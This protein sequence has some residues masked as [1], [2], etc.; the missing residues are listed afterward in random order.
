MW[1]VRTAG[2]ALTLAL[3]ASMSSVGAYAQTVYI[4]TNR[5][6]YDEGER[7][8]VAGKVSDASDRRPVLVRIS[9][10][11]DDCARQNVRPLRDGSF[12]SRPMVISGC[13]LG[14][15][16]VTATHAGITASTS[17][18]VEGKKEVSDSLELRAIRTTVSEAQ[19]AVNTRMREVL[20]ANLAIPERAAD[21]Y[22]RG[23]A[24]ASLTLQAI[25]RGNA[26]A[27]AEHMEVTLAYFEEALDL[28]SPE[29]L[30]T[31]AEDIREEQTRVSTVS[32][33]SGR[34]QDMFRRLVDLADKNG[35]A[36]EKEFGK[37]DKI[38]GDAQQFLNERKT[39]SAAESL[40]A[41]DGLIEEARQK[42]IRQAEG[43]DLQALSSATGRLEN[44]ANELRQDAAGVP[45]VL[46]Q[47]NASFVHINSAK[48]SIADGD[49]DS[50]K[51]SLDLA[52]KKL[53]EAKK[54]LSRR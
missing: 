50:A 2:I 52:L 54:I 16:S 1:W 23:A 5:G 13:G 29:K 4:A 41:A 45:R 30:N 21:A 22:G 46:A 28:L 19:N 25:E 34:L 36:A 47:V 51:A 11:G 48:S 24:K 6:V 20:D 18:T 39:N 10:D 38:L 26:E 40:M 37:I 43:N 3:I 33:W 32:E 7:I 49:Y 15:F 8:V 17:F 31:V 9:S 44:S 27:S 12:V 14:E 53:E 42:L 35:V